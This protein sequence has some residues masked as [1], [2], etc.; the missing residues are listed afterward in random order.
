[1]Y[2]KHQLPGF[3]RDYRLLWDYKSLHKQNGVVPPKG[4]KPPPNAPLHC[5]PAAETIIPR[6]MGYEDGRAR[7]LPRLREDEA[8]A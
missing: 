3:C 5:K 4:T 8:V 1:M 2:P 7:F 6:E